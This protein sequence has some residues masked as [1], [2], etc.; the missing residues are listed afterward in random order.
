M[1]E[2]VAV[3][4]FHEELTRTVDLAAQL[5]RLDS[6]RAG[7][8]FNDEHG[9]ASDGDRDRIGALC[10]ERPPVVSALDAMMSALAST[11]GDAWHAHLADCDRR[12]RALAES[13][14]GDRHAGGAALYPLER[15][16]KNEPCEEVAT[17]FARAM[18]VLQSHRKTIDMLLGL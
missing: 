4:S 11:H 17:T 15:W 1:R 2:V 16:R 5:L 10:L 3:T 13:N 6:E 12:L 18:D 7:L 9:W 14:D 8:E